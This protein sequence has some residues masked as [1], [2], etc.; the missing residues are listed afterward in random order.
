MTKHYCLDARAATEHF[1]GIGRYVSNLARA[2]ALELAAGEELWLL[3]D[4]SRPS[5][6]RLPLANDKVHFVKTAVSPFSL[7]QQWHIPRLLRRRQPAIYH[8]PYYLMP[9]RVCAPTLVTLYDLIPQLFPEHVSWRARLL[10]R[11]ATRFALKQAR[12]VITISEAARQDLLASFSIRGEVTAIPLAPEGRFHPQSATEIQ[13]VS[14][15]YRLPKQY[16][17]YLGGNKPHKN[18]ARLV[19]AWAQLIA[20]RPAAPPLVIAG[21][22]DNRYPESRQR[23]EILR[24]GDTVRF[25]GPVTDADLPALYS[26]ALFFVFPSLYEGFGLPVIE[27]MAC[28]TAVICAHTSSLAEVAGDAA[29]IVNPYD[30]ADIARQISHFLTDP[31]LIVEYRQRAVIQAQQFSWQKTAVATLNL[32]RRYA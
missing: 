3:V 18:L 6:W 32:Y 27:A 20:G 7:S 10:F 23:A 9:Y 24:L 11:I 28:G 5:P 14:Q 31:A 25:L 4:G 17:F 26:G 29:L 16:I 13:R 2:L 21:A 22:W 15:K 19:E 30:A 8:S 1:P 12:H